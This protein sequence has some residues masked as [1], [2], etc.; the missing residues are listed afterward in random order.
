M[1]LFPP[2]MLAAVAALECDAV[3]EVP[4]VPDA[5]QPAARRRAGRRADLCDGNMRNLTAG[6]PSSPK[7]MPEPKAAR[8]RH[9]KAPWRARDTP[10]PILLRSRPFPP[11]PS[12]PSSPKGTQAATS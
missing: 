6:Y 3:A 2:A 5:P 12:A 1:T 8:V 10:F 7:F 4:G 11:R 9:G